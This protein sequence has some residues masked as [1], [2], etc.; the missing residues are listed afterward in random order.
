[1]TIPGGVLSF[2]LLMLLSISKGKLFTETHRVRNFLIVILNKNYEI[3]GETR[4]GANTFNY[5]MYFIGKK[6]LYLSL[7]NLENPNF[8]EDKLQFQCFT[9][10]E[11]K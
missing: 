10:Q 5:R 11:N 1:M 7:N 3:I 6:G 2:C 8:D 4:F 9:L